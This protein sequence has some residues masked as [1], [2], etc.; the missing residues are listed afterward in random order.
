MRA[1][2]ML[3][4]VLLSLLAHALAMLGA[5]VPMPVAPDAAMPL[6]ARLVEQPPPRPA[7]RTDVATELPPARK[8]HRSAPRQ[9]TFAAPQLEG[10]T[11]LAMPVETADAATDALPQEEPSSLP[12]LLS[13]P[14]EPPPVASAT[15]LAPLPAL[16]GS[17]QLIYTL[18]LGPDNVAVGRSVLVWKLDRSSYRLVSDSETTGIVELFRP[19]RLTYTSEGRVTDQGLRPEIFAMSRTRRGRTDAAQARL[20]WDAGQ[21]TYGR[22]AEQRTV[23]LPP[24][25]QDIVSFLFQL[26]LHPPLPGRVRMPITNGLRFETYELEV[27][28]EEKI[29][30]PLGTL[31]TLPLR[32]QRK[33]ASESIEVWL[34]VDYRY[35]PVKVR[36]IDRDGNTSG[37]QV[38]SEIRISQ[39]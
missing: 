31:N 8:T 10:A 27:L 19:Q 25:S 35:L 38:V 24:P 16:P 3:A 37:E 33:Q 26:A 11:A 28:A 14:A 13:S 21:L 30:T 4:P 1:H 18:H 29:E 6:V 32:Q 34:A 7:S 23:A 17:V 22:P 20:D 2:R 5:W 36:F 9:E 15:E 39:Q 12:A